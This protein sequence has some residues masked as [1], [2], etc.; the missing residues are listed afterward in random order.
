[1]LLD[2]QVVRITSLVT[3]IHHVLYSNVDSSP[4]KDRLKDVLE[5]YYQTYTEIVIKAG[6]TAPFSFKE[7]EIEYSMKHDYGFIVGLF[8]LP[9][10]SQDVEDLVAIDQ[11][12][13]R[14]EA[15]DIVAENDSKLID[16]FMSGG[17]FKK[18]TVAMFEDMINIVK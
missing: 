8:M 17:A 16:L 2:L 12:D 15:T 9:I 13:N 7:L 6:F 10:V 3:D 18:G 11:L 1:M 14:E 5:I 4:R